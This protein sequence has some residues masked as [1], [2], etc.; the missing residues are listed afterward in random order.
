M[1]GVLRHPPPCCR[2]YAEIGNGLEIGYLLAL[3]A[4]LVISATCFIR[5]LESGGR[6]ARRAP[7]TV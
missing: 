5:S 1:R 6:K 4:A 3:L 7:G 2:S